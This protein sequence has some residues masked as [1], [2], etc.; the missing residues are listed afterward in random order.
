MKLRPRRQD[1]RIEITPLIDVVFL[2]LTFFVFA[3]VLTVRADL[4]D[5][6]LPT[7]GGGRPAEGRAAVT[8][9]L[10]T[11][12][13]ITAGGEP[14][15]LQELPDLVSQLLEVDPDSALLVATDAAAPAERLLAVFGRLTEAGLGEFSII[16][17]P[18]G[19]AGP[20]QTSPPQTP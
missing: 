12:G 4:L 8:V 2:L 7:F 6:T 13:S 16:G 3:L 19:N 10:L 5:I 20:P 9:E 14:T 17:R 15:S 18:A 1:L 11:D